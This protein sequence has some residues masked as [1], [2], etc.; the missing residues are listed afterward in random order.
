MAD[1]ESS[2]SGGNGFLYFIVGGVVVVVA[3]LG[4]LVLGGK[5]PGMGGEE[6]VKIELK[7]DGGS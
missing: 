6:K 1:Q 3:I 7:T 5:M 4:Y 2:G